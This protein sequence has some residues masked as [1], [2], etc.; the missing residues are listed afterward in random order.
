MEATSPPFPKEPLAPIDPL[1]V[2]ELR[3]LDDDVRR[4]RAIALIKL[5]NEFK[6]RKVAF[7]KPHPK[8]E[9]F[10]RL[11]KDHNQRC[12]S[13]GNQQGKTTAGGAESSFHAS[14]QYPE[15][16]KGKVFD[17]PILM[18]VCG[19]NGAKVRD[20][21][22]RKIMGRRGAWGTGFMPKD[23]IL[24]EPAMS[25]GTTGLIDFVDIK[26]VSGGTSVIKF[27]SY[28]MDPMS[29]ESD[30]VDVAWCDEE[31]PEKVY[32]PILARFVDTNGMVYITSTPIHGVSN[33]IRRFY[34]PGN[35]GPDCAW[36]QAGLKDALHIPAHRHEQILRLFPWHERKARA[37]GIPVLGSGNVYQTPDEAVSIA[38]FEIPEYFARIIGIDIGGGSSPTAWVELAWDRDTDIVYIVDVYSIIEPQI[39]VH[40]SAIK[41][42]GQWIPVAWPH[43]AHQHERSG[44][45]ETYAEIYRG[46]GV[47]MLGLHSQFETGG[48]QKEP[49]VDAIND[50]LVSGRLRVFSH[51]GAWFEEYRMYHRKEGKIVKEFDHLMDATRMAVMDLR[52]AQ[53]QPT[54]AGMVDTV[55]MD[56]DPLR[57]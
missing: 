33:V 51:L 2:P 46:H 24:G 40:A 22:Q 29:F 53:T 5:V 21:A 50:R 30:P 7:Y 32:N 27:L 57:A 38:A 11:G 31:P 48:Y 42:R 44:D 6:T 17:H 16:W 18:W 10:H 8:Q 1:D 43:D 56:Y 28:D 25:K 36:I 4:Q 20:N 13:A 23:C 19:V 52:Y 49:G 41:Q 45:G 14:G 26:H 34:P 54:M 15:D 35:A 47:K 39:S 12:F 3:E 55:G 37:E 9:L